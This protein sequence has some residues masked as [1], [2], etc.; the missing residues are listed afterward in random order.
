[1]S[2]ISHMKQ[3]LK[4][5]GSKTLFFGLMFSSLSFFGCF[6]FGVL[7]I[8]CATFWPYC[9]YFNFSDLVQTLGQTCTK[10]L[11]YRYT[12]RI[13]VWGIRLKFSW[14]W[15]GQLLIVVVWLLK[16]DWLVSLCKESPF[17][18]LQAFL[19]LLVGLRSYLLLE[20]MLS[21]VSIA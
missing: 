6:H 19:L 20:L 10:L 15:Y 4:C 14:L 16:V 17:L 2:P 7:V 13:F 1:M 9:F 21:V 18:Q 11:K 8:L 5:F 12:I 3:C